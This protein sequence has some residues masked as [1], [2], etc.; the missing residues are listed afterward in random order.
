MEDAADLKSASLTGVGV[1]IPSWAPPKANLHPKWGEGT[2]TIRLEST[3]G[4]CSV[5]AEEKPIRGYRWW[6]WVLGV[7]FVIPLIPMLVA[8]F[9]PSTRRVLTPLRIWLGW[10]VLIVVVIVISAVASDREQGIAPTQSQAPSPSQAV[11]AKEEER[12]ETVTAQA[13]YDAREEN[14]TRFDDRYKGKRVRVRGQIVKI[15]DGRVTLGVDATGFGIDEMGLFGVDLNDLPREVQVDVN[16]GQQFTAVCK[17][18]N[19]TIG[20]I[21]MEDCVAE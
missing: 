19:Y 16:K 8:V 13:L 9:V 3:P 15:D 5:I 20:T 1:R 10:A 4:G 14:A 6:Q 18:G 2:V 12:V 11:E 17:V 7:L 21:H